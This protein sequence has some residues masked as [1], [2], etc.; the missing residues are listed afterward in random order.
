MRKAW[1]HGVYYS[2]GA[3][4]LFYENL[5]GYVCLYGYVVGNLLLDMYIWICWTLLNY[6]VGLDE[7]VVGHAVGYVGYVCMYICV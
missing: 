6:V 3:S 2:S 5:F 4:L 1:I 7:Y